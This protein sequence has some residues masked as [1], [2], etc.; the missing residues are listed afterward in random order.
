MAITIGFGKYWHVYLLHSF[1]LCIPSCKRKSPW[2]KSH[3]PHT[4]GQCIGS[5]GHHTPCPSSHWSTGSGPWST[6]HCH[7]RARDRLLWND[8]RQKDQRPRFPLSLPRNKWGAIPTP[9]SPPMLHG[10]LQLIYTGLRR[11]SSLRTSW[12]IRAQKPWETMASS[13]NT[14]SISMAI[15][16]AFHHGLWRRQR[17][18]LW[19]ACLSQKWSFFSC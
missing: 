3:D 4:A 18:H 13:R 1:L 11:E 15:S 7:Y 6:A 10:F 17:E 2:C 9:L 8:T 14:L 16:G 12:T 5:S 19:G